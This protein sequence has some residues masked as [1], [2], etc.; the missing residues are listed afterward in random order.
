[1]VFK[2]IIL[3]YGNIID[4]SQFLSCLKEYDSMYKNVGNDDIEL[5]DLEEYVNLENSDLVLIHPYGCCSSNNNKYMF[6]GNKLHEIAR[7][8]SNRYDGIV[9]SYTYKETID[10]TYPIDEIY[11]TIFKVDPK[12]ICNNCYHYSSDIIC[13][14]CNSPDKFTCDDVIKDDDKDNF[15]IQRGLFFF[16]DDCVSCT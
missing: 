16:I 4:K 6:V 10:G 8:Y 1:M 11:N 7:M 3:G 13:N 5:R 15:I 9:R 12:L 14:K 2:K